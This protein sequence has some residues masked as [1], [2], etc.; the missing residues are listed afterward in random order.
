MLI[1]ESIVI[2]IKSVVASITPQQLYIRPQTFVTVYYSWKRFTTGYINSRYKCGN[3]STMIELYCMWM[4]DTSIYWNISFVP[5]STN[6]FYWHI[7]CRGSQWVWY[8]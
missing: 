8:R 2:Q 6:R 4:F 5:L 1:L 7:W 3:I